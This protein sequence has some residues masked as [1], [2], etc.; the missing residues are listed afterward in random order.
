MTDQRENRLLFT[1]GPMLPLT[2]VGELAGSTSRALKRVGCTEIFFSSRDLTVVGN[3]P[4]AG[5]RIVEHHDITIIPSTRHRRMLAWKCSCYGGD[6]HSYGSIGGVVTAA[7]EHIPTGET[8]TV[9]PAREL[10]AD[11]DPESYEAT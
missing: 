7:L 2:L 9:E 10:T 3:L 6:L 5:T 11:P 8:W 1:L 4:P